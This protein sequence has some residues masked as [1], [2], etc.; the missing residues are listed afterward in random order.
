MAVAANCLGAQA[1]APKTS[2]SGDIGFVSASGNTRLTTLNVGDK[3]VR[4]DDRWTL[5]ELGAYVY[6]ETK[7]VATANQLRFAGRADYALHPRIAVFAGASF[8]RNKFAGFDSRADEV[9][10]LSWK[11][12]TEPTDSLSLDA[13]GVLTQESDVDGTHKSF[14]SARLAAAYKHGFTKASYF[15]QLAEY[16]PNLQTSGAY[17]V[18]TESA[19]VAPISS[20]VGIKAGYVIRYDSKPPTNFGTTDRLLTTGVQISY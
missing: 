2:F 14:P 10:G 9:A 12:L 20:H 4:T 3:L 19:I 7:G 13:G 8:E 5:S 15:Q 17:R 1:A 16:L 11:A 6:G 18:N